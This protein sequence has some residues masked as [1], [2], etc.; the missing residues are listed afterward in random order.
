VR[1][2]FIQECDCDLPI[3]MRLLCSFDTDAAAADEFMRRRAQFHKR[4]G[5]NID[6]ADDRYYCIHGPS[7][8]VIGIT[9]D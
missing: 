2:I 3:L 7:G 9:P 8:H 6:D 5:L 4:A 1:G